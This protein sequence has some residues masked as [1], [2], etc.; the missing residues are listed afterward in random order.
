MISR[1]FGRY[2]MFSSRL[3]FKL[4]FQKSKKLSS[5]TLNLLYLTL[6]NHNSKLHVIFFRLTRFYWD[7]RQFCVFYYVI[8]PCF[9]KIVV[10]K[11]EK[12]SSTNLNLLYLT[13]NNHNSKMTCKFFLFDQVLLRF[14]TI[15]CV[16]LRYRPLVFS[17]IPTY[18]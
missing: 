4:L 8:D 16:L 5:T 17:K 2:L 18:F 6:N 10:P 14:Q 1:H 7:F 3:N 13:L 15:L 9:F 11:K 12:L